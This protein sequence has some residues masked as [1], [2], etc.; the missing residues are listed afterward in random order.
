MLAALVG[1][2]ILSAAAAPAVAQPPAP[3]APTKPA[4]PA[5]PAAAAPAP[6]PPEDDNPI[7]DLDDLLGTGKKD[8]AT[9]PGRPAATSDLKRRLDAQELGDAFRQAVELMGDAAGRI[10]SGRD[11]GATTQRVQQDAIRRLEVL[12]DQL[13]QQSRSSQRQQQSGESDQDASRRQQSQQRSARANESRGDN[14][15]EVDPPAR[16]DGPLGPQVDGTS[17][18][19]ALPE[20]VR[21]MLQ[22]GRGDRFSEAYRRLTESYYRK[23]AEEGRR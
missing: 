11:T 14:N 8:P 20:R 13:Q 5:P 1:A 2:A 7:P 23:L 19:G 10:N 4:T 22:Q 3:P 16:R 12:L 6:Q 9:P 15:A 18:W 21:Q 17:A